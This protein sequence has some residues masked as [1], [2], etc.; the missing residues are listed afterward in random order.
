[1]SLKFKANKQEFQKFLKKVTVGNN[2]ED[3]VI[4][5]TEDKFK[6]RGL[7]KAKTFYVDIVHTSKNEIIENDITQLV[8]NNINLF[9]NTLDKINGDI[10]ELSFDGD[11]IKFKTDKK[12]I[13]L[14][15]STPEN[16]NSNTISTITFNRK[17]KVYKCSTGEY[18]LDKMFTIMDKE[19]NAINVDAKDLGVNKVEF[20]FIP[21][22]NKINVDISNAGD[23]IKSF[24]DTDLSTMTEPFKVKF[25]DDFR[26]ITETILKST[27]EVIFFVDGTNDTGLLIYADNCYYFMTNSN[28]SNEF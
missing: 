15:A 7:N 24:I 2:I 17:E 6:F 13:E 14:V 19:I 22:E 18:K 5:V 9:N 21:A 8:I 23:S 27:E 4:E 10:I 3:A 16:I 28:D 12:K 1:M 26:K 20:E 25:G 11:M